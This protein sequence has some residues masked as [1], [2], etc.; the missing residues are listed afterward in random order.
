[1]KKMR[2]K[3]SIF[4]VTEGDY[5]NL[6]LRHIYDLYPENKN[7]FW[8]PYPRG[9]MPRGKQEIINNLN[10]LRSQYGRDGNRYVGIYDGDNSSRS[11][12]SKDFKLVKINKCLEY[13]ILSILDVKDCVGYKNSNDIK[14]FFKEKYKINGKEDFKNFL[15]IYLTKRKIDKKINKL[16]DLKEI[17]GVW[18]I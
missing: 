4:T 13:L 1:M 10:R 14:N 15:S 8:R 3:R 7:I 2:S 16:P 9:D 11:L 18:K 5:D 12:Q 17:L 6:F